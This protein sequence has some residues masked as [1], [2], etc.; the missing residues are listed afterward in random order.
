V[1][2]DDNIWDFGSEVTCPSYGRAD[3]TLD[4]NSEVF[5]RNPGL[6]PAVKEY[7]LERRKGTGRRRALAWQTVRLGLGHLERFAAYLEEIGVRRWED[8]TPAKWAQAVTLIPANHF[9]SPMLHHA[10][11]VLNLPTTAEP[12]YPIPVNTYK[13]KK[14]TPP[15]PDAVMQEVI[16]AALAWEPRIPQLLRLQMAFS[17]TDPWAAENGIRTARD[18]KVQLGMAQT[19]AMILLLASTGMRVSELVS[20]K[21]GSAQTLRR[22]TGFLWYVWGTVFKFHGMGC[23]VRW[24]GGPIGRRAYQ[25]L[26]DLSPRDDLCVSLWYSHRVISGDSVTWRI[27]EWLRREGIKGLDGALKIH[28]HQFRRTFARQLILHS[29]VTLLGLKDQL[30][31]KKLSMTDYY[32]GCDAE[33]HQA[34]I[35]QNPAMSSKQYA[36]ELLA[37]LDAEGDQ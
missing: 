22:E 8:L 17:R 24:Y 30:K 33:L 6:L 10:R 3:R 14:Q 1:R 34:L 2:M 27:V 26:C 29:E 7:L 19:A 16:P 28:P 23:R 18:I 12:L 35:E 5:Q 31:H 21:R 25:M 32:V 20:L 37:D 13:P 11:G 36:D 9:Q 4:F 15:I